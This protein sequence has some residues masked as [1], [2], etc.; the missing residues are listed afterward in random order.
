LLLCGGKTKAHTEKSI[1]CHFI[2]HKSHMTALGLKLGVYGDSPTTNCLS[3]GTTWYSI[4]T[5]PNNWTIK[6]IQFLPYGKSIGSW[7]CLTHKTYTRHTVQN[8]IQYDIS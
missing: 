4:T 2:H 1:R 6:K 7:I 3:Y 8:M 5:Q